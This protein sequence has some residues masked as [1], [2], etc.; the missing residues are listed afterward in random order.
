MFV[1]LDDVT[2]TALLSKRGGG[3]AAV[4]KTNT[5]VVIAL[6]EKDA[7]SS[8]GVQNSGDC[9]GQVGAMAAYLKE[10]GY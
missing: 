1:A 5:G 3:G 4:A 2:Q 8:N 6:W 7:P 9:A 10:Q